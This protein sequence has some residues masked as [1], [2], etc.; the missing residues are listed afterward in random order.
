MGH[1]S[2]RVLRHPDGALGIHEV[3]YDDDGTPHS[4]STEPVGFEAI[5]SRT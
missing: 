5:H 2:Y 3:F 4:C 1:W